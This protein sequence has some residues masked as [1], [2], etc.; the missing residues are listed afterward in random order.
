[1]T[2]FG[3]PYPR[4]RE[5]RHE[6]LQAYERDHPGQ[7]PFDPLDAVVANLIYEEGGGLEQ[8]AMRYLSSGMC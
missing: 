5:P 8:A 3:L 1:M 6:A 7:G 2:W 4:R